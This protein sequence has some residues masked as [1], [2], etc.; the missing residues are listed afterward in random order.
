MAATLKEVDEVRRRTRAT[1]HPAWFPMLLFGLFGLA[2]APFCAI[3]DGAGQGWFWAV[4]GPLG[5]VL[6]ARHY[7]RRGMSTG[8]CVRGGPYWAVAAA[9]IA[10]AWLA[11]TSGSP[12]VESAGPM[13]VVAVGYLIFARL[14]RSVPVAVCAV[15]LAAA[16]AA[17]G[18]AGIGDRCVILSLTFAT[19]FVATGILLRRN[20]RG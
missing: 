8:A 1:V 5:G 12:R 6:T 14:E 9:I 4:A 17:V 15:V 11:G 16:A 3:D 13:I 7:H 2:S 10:G 20:E 19:V 18:L